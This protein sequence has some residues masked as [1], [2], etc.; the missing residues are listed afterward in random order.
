ML[1]GVAKFRRRLR[2]SSRD[3]Q[4]RPGGSREVVL[5]AKERGD[6]VV[7]IARMGDVNG[8]MNPPQ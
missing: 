2:R 6:R 8:A 3:V 7:L 5:G 4:G 1:A